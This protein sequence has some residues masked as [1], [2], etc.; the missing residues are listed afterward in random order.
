MKKSKEM[1]K[2]NEMMEDEDEKEKGKM[3]RCPAAGLT[4]RS[5]RE[6]PQTAPQH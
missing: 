1:M 4:E 3:L 2:G 6:Q 5:R